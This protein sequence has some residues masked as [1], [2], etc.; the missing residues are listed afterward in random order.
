MLATG[1]GLI[2]FAQQNPEATSFRNGY[3]IAVICLLAALLVTVIHM[4][5]SALWHHWRQEQP[6]THQ[7]LGQRI[8]R[9][10]T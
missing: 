8:G 5:V 9:R 4:K 10:R 2:Y 6:G 3:A 7:S 1:F